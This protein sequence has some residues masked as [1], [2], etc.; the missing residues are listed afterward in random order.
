MYG[1]GR[2]TASK[3]VSKDE[4]P[5]ARNASASDE[6]ASPKKRRKVNHGGYDHTGPSNNTKTLTNLCN[7]QHVSTAGAR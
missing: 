3:M 5:K 6:H 2:T 7:E 1:N 4:S